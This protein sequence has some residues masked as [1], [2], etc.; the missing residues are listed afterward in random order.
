M[1]FVLIV[2][3]EDVNAARIR[4]ILESLELDFEY[5]LVRTAEAVIASIEKQKPDVF[6]GD[7]QMSFMSGTELFSMVEMM[8]PETIRIVMTDGNKIHETVSFMNE[9]K[10][11]KIIIKPCRVADDLLVPIHAAFLY[12]E[13]R[14]RTNQKMREMESG[15]NEIEE[16][17][18]RTNALWKSKSDDLKRVQNIICDMISSNIEASSTMSP[19]VSER[20]IRW[21]QWMVEEYIRLVV[22]GNANY[23]QVFEGLIAFCHEPKY[24]CT[25]QMKKNT[26]DEIEP[27]CMNEIAYV[28]RLLTGICKDM[29][30]TYHIQVIIDKADKAYILRVRY[31]I[32]KDEDGAELTRAH[33]VRTNEIREAVGRATKLAIEAL[34]CKTAVFKKAQEDIVNV[35]IPR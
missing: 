32:E 2:E 27:M 29:Q 20:V 11:F 17:F 4:T 6:I 28:L 15:W 13:Q 9:C 10:T 21:Y 5:E 25:F 30:R 26:P 18:E 3:A 34:G 7:M 31:E 33:R 35:A 22:N 8:S 24:D 12:Q 1:R 14:E 23:E 19:K 16:E